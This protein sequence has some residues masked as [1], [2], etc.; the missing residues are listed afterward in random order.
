M[1][2]NLN[3]QTH[4]EAARA[5][6]HL[7]GFP[8][9]F[10]V[11]MAVYLRD[12]PRLLEVAIDSVFSNSL[13]PDQFVL[14]ADGPLS[15]GLERVLKTLQARHSRQIEM[16]RLP[17]NKG[18]AH[19]LNAG[20]SHI[21]LPWVM[22]ADADD[23]N[24]PHRF[25]TLAAMLTT[26]PSLELMS[27]AI[28]EVDAHGN[29]IAVRTV[30]ESEHEIRRFAKFRCPFNHMAVAYRRD[31]VLACGGYPDVHLKEDYALWCRMLGKSICAANSAE[32][33]V[34]A[35]AGREM[36]RRRGGWRYAKA[37]WALQ[38]VMVACG[39]KSRPRAWFDG[40]V[41]AAGFLAP[42]GLRGAIYEI[43]LRKQ[44]Q[45]QAK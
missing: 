13:Q 45:R 33:L 17:V 25:A 28:L 12:D 22:R 2:T 24:L 1:D 34:H 23:L 36:Y 15:E 42:A 19:A 27:S 32:V 38:G 31:A 29:A 8:G 20:L 9:G 21:T 10:A 6:I 14:V 39:L 44:L 40:L 37:E 18:L 26:Q 5:P 3:H 41:R 7:A 35:T 11:L 4:I 16:L 43:V 30:P